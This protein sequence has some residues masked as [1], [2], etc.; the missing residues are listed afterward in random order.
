MALDLLAATLLWCHV[1]KVQPAIPLAVM[2]NES[3]FQCGPLGKGTFI[4]PGGIHKSFR[5]KWA[6][7]DP[8]ENIRVTVAAFEGVHGESAFKHRLKSYNKTWWKDNYLRDTLAAYR[9]YARR[10][11]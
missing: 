9:Q 2:K 11:P 7:D 5:R 4:G 8:F 1:Y 6:I 3:N 10:F